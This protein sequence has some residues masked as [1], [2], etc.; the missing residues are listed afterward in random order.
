MVDN[1]NANMLEV[2][3]FLVDRER[4]LMAGAPEAA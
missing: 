3:D 1:S 4:R 2:A